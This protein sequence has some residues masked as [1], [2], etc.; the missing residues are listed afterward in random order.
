MKQDQL[1]DIESIFP[2][3]ATQCAPQPEDILEEFW[4]RNSPWRSLARTLIVGAFSSKPLPL[5]LK[6]G[7][8]PSR[9]S[10]PLSALLGP[11]SLPSEHREA[12]VAYLLSLCYILPNTDMPIA[13]ANALIDFLVDWL[14]QLDSLTT[15]DSCKRDLGAVMDAIVGMSLILRHCNIMPAV[16]IAAKSL[17]AWGRSQQMSEQADTQTSALPDVSLR[18]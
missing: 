16:L 5:T 9:L 17:Q 11:L 15:M 4:T 7:L 18:A 3:T 10:R 13:D 14:T 12:S 2:T 8:D 1:P 6:E